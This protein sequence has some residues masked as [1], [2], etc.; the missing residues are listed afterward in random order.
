VRRDGAPIPG[1]PKVEPW[2]CPYHNSRA[3]LETIAR[4]ARFDR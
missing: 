2:K 3:A 4:V 1:L